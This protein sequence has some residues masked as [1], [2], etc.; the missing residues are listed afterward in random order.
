MDKVFDVATLPRD[1]RTVFDEVVKQQTSYILTQGSQPAAVVI[2]YQHYLKYMQ[3][4]AAGILARFDQLLERMRAV[5]AQ[6]SDEE[7]EADLQVATR[8]VRSRKRER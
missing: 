2:P 6:F 1:F 8:T 3:T 5:N 7:V 4:E